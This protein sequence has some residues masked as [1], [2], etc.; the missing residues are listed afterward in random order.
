MS[1]YQGEIADLH[2]LA[3]DWREECLTAEALIATLATERAE[4]RCAIN[5]SGSVPEH[6]ALVAL[7]T[8][9]RE[10]SELVDQIETEKDHAEQRLATL[11]AQVGQLAR[12]WCNTRMP[13]DDSHEYWRKSKEE[14]SGAVLALL[15]LEA[16]HD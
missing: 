2:R 6:R 8:A 9:Q 1:T 10:D 12:D 11:R 3:N 4:L 13:A 5:P 14:C 7:A 15:T 16:D